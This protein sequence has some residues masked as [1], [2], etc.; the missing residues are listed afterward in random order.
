MSYDDVGRDSS[1][2]INKEQYDVALG[3]IS[4]NLEGSG[5]N[6]HFKSNE[7]MNSSL[8]NILAYGNAQYMLPGGSWSTTKRTADLRNYKSMIDLFVANNIDSSIFNKFHAI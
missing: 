3:L 5:I 8:F 2:A 1:H 7:E 4:E 6:L